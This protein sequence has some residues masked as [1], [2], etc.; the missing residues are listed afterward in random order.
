MSKIQPRRLQ[1]LPQPGQ[2]YSIPNESLEEEY[3]PEMAARAIKTEKAL[4][5]HNEI[6]DMLERDRQQIDGE[7]GSA[8]RQIKAKVRKERRMSQ[9]S[10]NEVWDGQEQDVLFKSAMDLLDPAA[11]AARGRGGIVQNTE[12]TVAEKAAAR[13]ARERKVKVEAHQ[14]IKEAEAIPHL[15]NEEVEVLKYKRMMIL[16]AVM[17]AIYFGFGLT[18]FVLRMF[19]DDCAD[20]VPLF[21]L[22]FGLT[23][24]LQVP[25]RLMVLWPNLACGAVEFPAPKNGCGTCIGYLFTFI[26]VIE[27][28][29]YGGAVVMNLVEEVCNEDAETFIYVLMIT[30]PLLVAFWF[31]TTYLIDSRTGF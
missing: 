20:W 23:C 1:P 26:R 27:I 11:M 12:H 6:V 4:D 31:V 10:R 18:A 9:N 14:S 21:L 16:D 8:T 22:I 7:A 29:S 25:Y 5:D 2:P 17:V 13:E 3:D 30:W 15:S 28:G 24:L 19:G